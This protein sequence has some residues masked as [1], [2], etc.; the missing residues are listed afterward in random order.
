[1]NWKPAEIHKEGDQGEKGGFLTSGGQQRASDETHL[2]LIH[3]KI[4][5]A[6]NDNRKCCQK[7]GKV[8]I[9]ANRMENA[10]LSLFTGIYIQ[11]FSTPL[12]IICVT[13]NVSIKAIR[14]GNKSITTPI[15]IH[16]LILLII[17][18]QYRVA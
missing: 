18:L 17:P 7:K 5:G 12:T 15:S 11:I 13:E 14:F 6:F 4:S 8:S 2:P 9:K 16:Y 3:T 10:P 1:M